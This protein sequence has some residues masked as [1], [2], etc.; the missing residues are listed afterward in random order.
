L[1]LAIRKHKKLKDFYVLFVL[2]LFAMVFLPF[3][4][5]RIIFYLAIPLSVLSARGFSL[6]KNSLGKL[7]LATAWILLILFLIPAVSFSL[8]ER[9][10][11]N[12]KDYEMLLWIKENTPEE[13]VIASPWQVSGP[14]I[15]VIAERQNILGYL[16]EFVP[17]YLER[18]NDLERIFTSQ[19][20]S[21]IRYILSKYNAKYIY[22]NRYEEKV[23]YPGAIKRLSEMFDVANENGHAYIFRI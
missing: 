11:M 5:E 14:W 6:M 21:E 19:S 22:I 1:P 13:S 16:Q 12:E 10:E 20:E 7:G 23:L 18:R 17:D 9:S 15:P 4:R 8:T 3:Y 2:L